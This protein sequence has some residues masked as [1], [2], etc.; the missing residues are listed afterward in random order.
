MTAVTAGQNPNRLL[1]TS[2][3]LTR[4]LRITGS[5][6]IELEVTHHAVSGV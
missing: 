6:Q 3:I 4:D 1:F 2:G 5:P